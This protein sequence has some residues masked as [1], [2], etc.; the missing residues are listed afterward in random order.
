MGIATLDLRPGAGLGPFSLGMALCDALAEVETQLGVFDSIVVN[1]CQQEPLARDIVIAFPHLGF[2]LCFD[3]H[4]QRLHRIDVADISRLHLRF[5]ASL[6]GGPMQAPTFAHVYS[7]LGPTFPGAYNTEASCYTLAYPGMALLFPIPAHHHHCFQQP[8]QDLPMQLPDGSAPRLSRVVLHLP[9]EPPLPAHDRACAAGVARDGDGVMADAAAQGQREGGDGGRGVGA[10]ECGEGDGLGRAA[11][12]FAAL[13]LVMANG[14]V[15]M[16]PLM[17]QP[18]EAILFSHGGQ[19]IAFGDSAQDVWSELGRPCFMGAK[20]HAAK[21]IHTALAPPAL[22]SSPA[23]PLIHPSSPSLASSAPLSSSPPDYV[24]SYYTRGLDIIFSG[25]GYEV[26]KFVLHTNLPGQPDF[27]D[28]VKCNFRIPA[29]R[30]PAAAPA[31]PDPSLLVTPDSK[32]GHVQTLFGGGGR[33]AIQTAGALHRAFGPTF[34]YGFRHVAFEVLK[35][36]HIC[37][38]TLFKAP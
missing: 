24:W 1:Y 6:L 2:R 9:G 14:A 29:P 32:W 33:V 20:H 4:V 35:N 16:E 10:L 8:S 27:N 17:V 37:T 36:G 3:P 13:P 30:A 12:R 38:V 28:Y 31:L 15:Y 21:A 26:S 7:V 23:S 34:V 25:Q 19:R 5:G 22:S 11:E 18:G